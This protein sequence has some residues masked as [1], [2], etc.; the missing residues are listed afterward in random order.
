MILDRNQLK[1]ALAY[2]NDKVS[3]V[4]LV[5]TD[6]TFKVL[7]RPEDYEGYEYACSVF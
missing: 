6:G 3:N 1:Q 5:D 7:P 2:G 4:V